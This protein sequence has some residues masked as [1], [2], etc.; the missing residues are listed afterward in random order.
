MYSPTDFTHAVK[1][2]KGFFFNKAALLYPAC[3]DNQLQESISS[4][5]FTVVR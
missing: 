5:L 4:I 3:D 2:T 1:V